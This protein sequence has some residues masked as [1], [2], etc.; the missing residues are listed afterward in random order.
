MKILVK[1]L[2]IFIII[3]LSIFAISRVGES[4]FILLN[5]DEP[6]VFAHRGHVDNNVEN[7]NI[8][9][10]KSIDLGYTAIE[11]DI[12]ITKDGKLI[13]F[14]DDNATRLI[15][16]DKDITELYWDDIKNNHL[17]YFDEET[18]DRLMT[19]DEFL[20]QTSNST[21]VYLD[22]KS[23]SFA[24]ADSLS[25]ILKNNSDKKNLIIA[26]AN[27]MF[28]AYLKMNDPSLSVC[29]EGFNK[30]K[31]FLFYLFPDKYKPDY[32]SSFLFQVDENHMQFLKK[33]NLINNRIVYGVEAKN[34]QDAYDL[35]IKNII[36]DHDSSMQS[37]NEIQKELKANNF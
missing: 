5:N 29:L 33:N 21:I 6:I 19:L 35:G 34:I 28:L 15:G 37:I 8:S 20:K 36:L 12:S 23:S 18:P 22:F 14:H 25:N 30:G 4:N 32:Y 27:Y 17:L 9:F 1:I 11:T 24:I 7:S 13:I 10:Q 2:S 31:E 3:L 16:I 26:D